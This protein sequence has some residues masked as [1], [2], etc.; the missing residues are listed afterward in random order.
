MPSRLPEAGVGG[1]GFGIVYLE[2]GAHGL[3][4]VAG[5]VAGARDAVVDGQDGH[6]GRPDRPCGGRR[7]AWRSLAGSRP[8]RGDGSRRAPPC[9]KPRLAAD[10]RAGGRLVPQ[11]DG[12]RRLMRVLYVNQ[13]AQVS[14]A[15]RSLLSLLKGLEGDPEPL[16]GCPPG[17][18]GRCRAGDG[19]RGRSDRRD[20]GQL[21]V[22]PDPYEPWARGDGAVLAPGAAS[23][24]PLSPRIWSTPTRAGPP[25]WPCWRAGARGRRC[26]PISGT[27]SRRAASRGSCSA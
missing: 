24:L 6:P 1:E 16:V 9:R 8:R 27:G 11:C 4:S 14:G 23:G 10:R 26:S 13:T 17:R 12:V 3:P 7:R 18:A 22:A 21:P 2:A 19:D 20:A 5:N 15:E 25:C